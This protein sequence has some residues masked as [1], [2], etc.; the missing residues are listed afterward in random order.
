MDGVQLLK[1]LIDTQWNVNIE[2]NKLTLLSDF[3][4]IDTQWNVNLTH[5]T[6]LIQ[7]TRD[8]IDTQW[9]VNLNTLCA[10]QKAAQI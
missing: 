1:D 6:T 9:N 2:E 8:L 7:L 10:A 4:L 3:D 5:H